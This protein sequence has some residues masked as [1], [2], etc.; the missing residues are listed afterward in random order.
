[1]KK[2]EYIKQLREKFSRLKQEVVELLDMADKSKYSHLQNYIYFA[3]HPIFSFTEAVLILCENKKS[4]A[5]KVLLRTLF[6][7]H[8]DIIY[9]QLGNS[10]QKLAFS[11]ETMFHGRLIVLGE[12][13]DL[14]KEH[15]EHES[16]DPKNLFNK[17]YLNGEIFNQK[18]HKEAIRRANP[19]LSGDKH[20]QI[21]A[22]LCD[23]AEI[24]NARKGHFKSMYS[25]IYRYL[26]PLAHLNIEGLQAF[27]DQGEGGVVF[28]H[29]GNDED[30]IAT[31]AVE[32][33]IALCKDLYDNEILT[34]KQI[35]LIK[36]IQDLILGADI[37]FQVASK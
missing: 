14:I 31:Q 11:A 33:S 34:G 10:E 4:N 16:K 22:R 27:V 8:I 1:M 7:A 29:D 19:N 30:F 2:E 17:E 5:A 37:K 15:P 24:K 23:E 18:K 9:H 12:I 28:F 3:H 32:I 25:L 21:K 36:D 6:E 35:V 26:S 13:L 20:L